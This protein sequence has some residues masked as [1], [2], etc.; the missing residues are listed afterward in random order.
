LQATSPSEVSNNSSYSK[1][2]LKRIVKEYNV[3][4]VRRHVD[5]LFKRVEKHYAEPGEEHA[6]N[7]ANLLKGVWSACEQE[8]VKSTERFSRL[9]AQCYKE[10]GVTLEFTV[11]DVEAS[12]RRHRVGGHS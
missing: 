8:L 11:Q 7:P 10:T 12:F 2:S 4:D 1:S 6:G 5:A 9:I 3:K